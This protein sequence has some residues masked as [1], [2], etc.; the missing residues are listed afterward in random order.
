[1][2]NQQQPKRK[3]VEQQGDVVQ[4]GNEPRTPGGPGGD[5][6]NPAPTPGTPKDPL[7]HPGDEPDITPDVIAGEPSR[8]GKT[9]APTKRNP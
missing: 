3:G 7:T 5:V 1:M 9:V 6:R 2:E 4:P 8:P